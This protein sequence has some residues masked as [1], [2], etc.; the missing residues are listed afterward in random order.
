MED[1][2]NNV[3][4]SGRPPSPFTKVSVATG[5]VIETAVLCTRASG[6]SPPHR[7]KD[8]TCLVSSDLC[9]H[10]WEIRVHLGQDTKV[11]LV[12]QVRLGQTLR[13]PGPTLP[14][15]TAAVSPGLAWT[16]QDGKQG[17]NIAPRSPRA[18]KNSIRSVPF[19]A[20]VSV[21]ISWS[22]LW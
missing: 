20:S 7:W 8:W 9:C 13:Y 2:G 21:R 14:V 11:A 5:I 22:L 18:L 19:P 6:P 1:L 17:K 10:R 4:V 12:E 16:S 3:R 15:S